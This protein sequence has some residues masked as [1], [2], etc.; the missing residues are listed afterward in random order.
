MEAIPVNKSYAWA[1]PMPR[2]G[3]GTGRREKGQEDQRQS[4]G[5]RREATGR[6]GRGWG[7]GS[8]QTLK[9][10]IEF[11]GCLEL[12]RISRGFDVASRGVVKF[13][14]GSNTDEAVS[15]S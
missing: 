15:P 9:R 13:I 6:P 2:R 14:I 3:G 10:K 7:W 11:H 1:A 5:T 8:R 4:G 12:T